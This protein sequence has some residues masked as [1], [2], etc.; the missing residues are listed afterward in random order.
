MNSI[1]EFGDVKPDIYELSVDPAKFQRFIKEFKKLDVDL[2]FVNYQLLGKMH[3]DTIE[4]DETKLINNNG[5]KSYYYV[6]H[7][8]KTVITTD[9]MLEQYIRFGVVER[10]VLKNKTHLEN[11]YFNCVCKQ[12]IKHA[13]YIKHKTLNY[14]LII[15]VCCYKAFR[16]NKED[17]MLCAICRYPL[18][19]KRISNLLCKKC[20]KDK[21][22]QAELE[23]F[24]KM[25]KPKR[26]R[27]LKKQEM[28]KLK[29][30]LFDIDAQYKFYY[31]KIYECNGRYYDEKYE[32]IPSDYII[33]IEDYY[34]KRNINMKKIMDLIKFNK[35]RK[36]YIALI[37][38]YKSILK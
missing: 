35:I 13:Y 7:I 30:Q 33:W 27:Y 4:Y 20:N 17:S 29:T 3:I 21:E 32:D 14:T 24:Y 23:K 6:K 28:I 12:H 11:G 5:K 10:D 19:G 31:H 25:S 22:K 9:K 8:K 36:E 37:E 38:K 16:E 1:N 26:E 15:G 34:K 18:V 2:K